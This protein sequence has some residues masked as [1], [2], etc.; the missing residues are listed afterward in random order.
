VTIQVYPYINPI[1][2][3]DSI[4]TA[5]GGVTGS[6]TAAQRNAMY[7]LAEETMSD[8]LETFLLPTQIT[9]TY[10]YNKL[11][12]FVILNSTF[13]KSVDH[14]YFKNVK[15]EIYWDQAGTA[16]IHVSLRNDEY[17][18]VDLHTLMGSCN[19]HSHGAYPYQ[20]DI[21]Y[22]AGLP[23]GTAN[24][25]NMLMALTEY[26]KIAINELIGFGNEA[27]ADIG[28]QSFSNQQY[29]ETRVKLLRTAFGTSPQAQFINRLISKYKFHRWVGM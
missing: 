17:G 23:T 7:Q 13:I 27:P 4:Y 8:A 29:Q 14:V 11:S 24:H 3:T 19:C 2:L 15:E 9:G 28:V 10:L 5:Y 1:I 26:A 21:V 25:P 22:T 16:N 12:P 18:L 20:V 6:S